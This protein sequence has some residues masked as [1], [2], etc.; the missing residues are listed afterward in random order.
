MTRT[1]PLAAA[2]LA[3]ALVACTGEIAGGPPYL[4][5]PDATPAALADG[6][7][8]ADA[9]APD[10]AAADAIG[11]PTPRQR[12]LDR[13]AALSGTATVAGQHNREPNAEPRRWTDAIHATTGRYPG[14]WSGDFLFQQDN[15]DARDTMIEEAAAEWQAGA[16]VNLMWHACPP[17][18]GEPCEWE[19]GIKSHLDDAAWRDLVADDGALHAVWLARL[20]QIAVYLQALEDQGVAVLFRPLHE[21]NQGVFWWGGRPGPDG[22]RR[23]FQITHDYLVEEKGLSNLVWVWDVQDLSWDFADYDPGGAYWDVIALDVYGDGFT[24]A[25][26]EAI[27][28]LAGD[29]PMA[30]GECAR[31]PRPAELDAQPRWVFFMAWAELVY[32][33]NSEAEIVELYQTDRVV[34]LDELDGW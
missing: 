31:L 19:G 17:D 2:C 10:D 16:L 8:A 26:Y 33:S 15:I 6:A 1:A 3:S 27:R 24:A 14:L 7:A 4:S 21:M 12:V 11:A 20:D 18:Q 5:P 30:I 22:T 28:G 32:E 23:L 34:T 25:K 13:L 9:V 29:K